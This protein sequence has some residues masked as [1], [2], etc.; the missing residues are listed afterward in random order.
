MTEVDHFSYGLITPVLAYT[1]SVMG[2]LLGLI[3]TVKAR[4]AT[5]NRRRVWFLLL[6]AWAIGGTGI[7]VMHFIAM[8]GYGIES[9]EIRYDVPITTASAVLA[10]AA[11]A[12][13]LCLVG[14]GRPNTAK[15]LAGGVF[16]GLGVAGMHY[17]GVAAMRLDGSINFDQVLVVASIAIAVVAATVALWFT[18]TVQRPL[19]LVGS[20]LVMGIAVSGMHYTGMHAMHIHPHGSDGPLSGAPVFALLLPIVV[21]VVLAV[22]GLIYAV[23]A[24]PTPE[25]AEGAAYLATRRSLPEPTRPVPPLAEQRRM[26]D[27][28]FADGNRPAPSATLSGEPT[29]TTR[30]QSIPRTNR[31]EH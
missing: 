27:G 11:V 24:A 25:D 18:V 6:A 28:T 21:L 19:A 23:L 26:P 8:L 29:P 10:V 3:C 15:I 30:R 12:V 5:S 9:G 13:G 4:G 1:L 20:A 31:R 16:T 2:S 14:L 17:T 22:I 7:W